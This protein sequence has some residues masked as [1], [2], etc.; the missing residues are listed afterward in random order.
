MPEPQVDG[1]SEQLPSLQDVL[2]SLLISETAKEE[3]NR[4]IA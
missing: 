1:G 2:V 3:N 4:S